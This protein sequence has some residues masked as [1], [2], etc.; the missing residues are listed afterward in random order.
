ML[1]F[2]FV[3][4]LLGLVATWW[5]GFVPGTQSRTATATSEPGAIVNTD[6]ARQRGA[7]VSERVAQGVNRVAQDVDDAALTAK[8]KA[9]M[10]LDDL[11]RARDINVDTVD[12]AVALTGRVWSENERQRAVQL[13]KETNGVQSVVDRL[14]LTVAP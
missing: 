8:I 11:V 12:G 3:V 9:K 2:L 4:L 13:A 5:M 1:R 6:A 7:E 14:T 10:A